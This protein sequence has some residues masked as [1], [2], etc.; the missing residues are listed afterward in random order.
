MM[1]DH[2]EGYRAPPNLGQIWR[3]LAELMWRIEH[4]F[5]R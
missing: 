5:E 4:A 1:H 2:A 3:G